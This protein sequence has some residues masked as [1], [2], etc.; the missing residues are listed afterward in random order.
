MSYKTI[1]S[2]VIYGPKFESR[3]LSNTN[4]GSRETK[5]K[6][7]SD[8]G[9]RSLGSTTRTSFYGTVGSYA[10]T[11]QLHKKLTKENIE[12]LHQH[13]KGHV[14]QK[15]ER[16]ELRDIFEMFSIYYTDD[17]FENLFLKINTDR[18]DMV[19]WDELVSYMLLGF[20]DDFGDKAKE[21]LDPPIKEKP[22]TR[23]TRQRYQIVRI[24][25][26]PTVFPDQGVNMKQGAFVSIAMDGTVNFYNV[27]W[28]LQRVG[29]SQ[30][31]K[32]IYLYF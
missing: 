6:V 22:I 28:E 25:F 12:R 15:L 2:R 17:E 21:S 24:D 3:Y 20:E 8:V 5:E 27:D 18:D 30:S 9:T 7:K 19:D 16:S 4:S 13:F 1:K 23:R 10:K 29:K 31:R 26:C 14:I 32:C 11:P